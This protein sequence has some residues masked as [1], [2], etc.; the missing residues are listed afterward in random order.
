MRIKF[1]AFVLSLFLVYTSQSLDLSQKFK[2]KFGESAV[3]ARFQASMRHSNFS[4][5]GMHVPRRDLNLVI[6]RPSYYKDS[7]YYYSK[8]R[9]VDPRFHPAYLRH[10]L[11]K[12]FR[13]YSGGLR[14]L[15]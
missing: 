10:K 14:Y 9:A 12:S 7:R 1:T 8:A 2:A 15:D 5:V 4:V 3:K 6:D 13:G 11:R